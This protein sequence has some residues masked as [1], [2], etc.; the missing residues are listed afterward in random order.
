LNYYERHIGDYLKDTSHL[1]LL[2][3]GIYTRLLDVY[4]TRECG[5][6]ANQV[7]RLIGART[8]EER[9]ALETVL[10]EFFTNDDGHTWRQKRCDEVIAEHHAF[11]ERQRNNAAKRWESH[12]NATAEPPDMP[13]H[14]S[15][16][17]VGIPPT[18]TPTPTPKKRKT[19]AP[20]KRR[21]PDDF[22][23]SENLLDYAQQHLP[24]ANVDAMF[25]G[26]CGKAKAKGWEYADWDR[27]WQEFV[28]NCRKDS[29]HWAAGQY[30]KLNGGKGEWM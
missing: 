4:Y 23:L 13:P 1:T 9:Q 24:D 14:K 16:I 10:R 30:P 8:E 22:A 2:E 15:G 29:G 28:R 25:E 27:A 6:P 18:P 12:G 20:P 19:T 3:H 5:L 21:I 11:I 7:Q 26:F 17:E